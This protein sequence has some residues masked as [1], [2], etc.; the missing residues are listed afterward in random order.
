MEAIGVER[1]ELDRL[2]EEIGRYLALV[3]DLR[4]AGREPTWRTESVVAHEADEPRVS[5]VFGSCRTSR[6]L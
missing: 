5:G 3:D 6:W 4:A 1:L 2:F